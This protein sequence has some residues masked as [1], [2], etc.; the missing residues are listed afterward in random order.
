MQLGTRGCNSQ[1]HEPHATC[2]RM[3][4]PSVTLQWAC[5]GSFTNYSWPHDSRYHPSA[6]HAFTGEETG[7]VQ[8]RALRRV[9]APVVQPVSSPEPLCAQLSRCIL[10]HINNAAGKTTSGYRKTMLPGED[11]T[12][13]CL[14]RWLEVQES[15]TEEGWFPCEIAAIQT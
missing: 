14:E 9:T 7:I 6:P 1:G 10:C 8:L 5:C 11:R 4:L 12:G 13:V 3:L 2:V 15:E